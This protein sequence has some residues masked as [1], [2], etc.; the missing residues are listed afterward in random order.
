MLRSLRLITLSCCFFSLLAFA[1]LASRQDTFAD[2]EG[3][4]SLTLPRGWIAITNTDRV[5]GKTDFQ[6]VYGIR[7]NGALKISTMQ[8][9]PKAEMLAVAQQHEQDNLRFQPGYTKG[10]FENFMAGA[11][12]RAGSLNTYDY[13]NVAGQPMIGRTYYL[14]VDDTTV[15]MLRFT[16]RV[17]TLGS[18]RNQTDAIARSFKLKE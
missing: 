14:R 7:E 11:G 18:L 10:K 1:G 13:K 17:S 9:D 8:V 2:P 6:V 12:Q 16:G 4:Y 3:K 5:T 15:Y